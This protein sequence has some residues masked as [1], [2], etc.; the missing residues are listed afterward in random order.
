MEN[1]FSEPVPEIH[2]R[3]FIIFIKK[4]GKDENKAPVYGIK[5]PGR[6]RAAGR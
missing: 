6:M 3:F 2:H 5:G 1:L 4:G